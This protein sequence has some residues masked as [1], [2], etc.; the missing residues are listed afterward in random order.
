MQ[1]STVIQRSLWF[2]GLMTIFTLGL[3]AIYWWYSTKQE[4]NS[5]GGTTPTFFLFFI[6]FINIYWFY[7]YSAN[8][9]KYIAKDENSDVMYFL[10]VMLLPFL[11]MLILQY[12]LNEFVENQKGA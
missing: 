11:N 3:Y 10:L 1:N 2:V 6:P 8:F 4:V 12:K 7:K 9:A 5:V